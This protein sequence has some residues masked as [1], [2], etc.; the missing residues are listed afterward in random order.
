M[1]AIEQAQRL[2]DDWNNGVP[3]QYSE[4]VDVLTALV[5]EIAQRQRTNDEFKAMWAAINKITERK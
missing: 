4:A 1:T 5:D 3:R 2:L